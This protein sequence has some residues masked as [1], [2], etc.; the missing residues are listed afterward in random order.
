MFVLF[1]ASRAILQFRGGSIKFGALTFWLTVWTIALLA[2]FYPEQTTKLAKLMGIGR[3]V[4]IVVYTA[5]ALLFYLVFRLHV[6]LENMRTE[7]S[8]LIREISLSQV[9]KGKLT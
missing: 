5:I 4:D 3:G 7:I 6:Y 2:I 8:R 1:A 9:K